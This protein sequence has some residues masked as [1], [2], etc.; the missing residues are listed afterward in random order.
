MHILPQGTEGIITEHKFIGIYQ[1]LVRTDLIVS[2][3][4]A[5]PCLDDAISNSTI[6]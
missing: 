5:S 4:R 3:I 1:V 6:C 2:K